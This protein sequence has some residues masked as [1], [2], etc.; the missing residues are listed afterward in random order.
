MLS[1]NGRIYE[2]A[3]IHCGCL[4][5][6]LST[7]V[8]FF[9]FDISV[10]LDMCFSGLLKVLDSWKCKLSALDPLYNPDIYVNTV[11]QVVVDIIV[12]IPNTAV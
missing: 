8:V 2:V 11:R 1:G 9:S 7:L 3:N 12:T 5:F 4:Y 6:I 10:I